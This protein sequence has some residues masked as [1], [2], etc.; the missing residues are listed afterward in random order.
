MR[1]SIAHWFRL[2]CS[3]LPTVLKREMLNGHKPNIC[4]GLC[5]TYFF[6][7]LGV[8][9]KGL[10]FSKLAGWTGYICPDSSDYITLVSFRT[11]GHCFDFQVPW[12]RFQKQKWLW[13]Q[14]HK[15]HFISERTESNQTNRETE[16]SYFKIICVG[17]FCL[18]IW[19][20][21]RFLP[22]NFLFKYSFNL[23]HRQSSNI[24]F[25]YIYLFSSK[26]RRTYI[27]I[28]EQNAKWEQEFVL[29]HKISL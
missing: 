11:R 24:T 20:H 22:K 27:L 9:L 8:G 3:L 4:W 12:A 25:C 23:D 15:H 26:S 19:F 7:C 2:N 16:R 17:I 14:E 28:L 29:F 21:A 13:G 5:A 1:C 10:I 18:D 6:P